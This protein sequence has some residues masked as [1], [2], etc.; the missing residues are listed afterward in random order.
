M[1]RK[2]LSLIAGFP[3]LLLIL[4]SGCEKEYSYEGGNAV[5]IIDTVSVSDPGTGNGAWICPACIGQDTAIESRWSFHNDSILVCGIIDTAIVNSERTA[6]TFFGP[7]SCSIDTGIIIS[8]LLDTELNKDLYNITSP[9]GVFYYYD[10]I[11]RT[12]IYISRHE[13]PFTVTIESYIHQ[14]RTATGSFSGPVFRPDGTSSYINSG[15]FK[16]KLF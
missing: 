9:K 3:L 6:F 10:N 16:V 2:S 8:V 5:V 12:D 14:T 7:S 15:K 4:I 11:G 1:I 13:S